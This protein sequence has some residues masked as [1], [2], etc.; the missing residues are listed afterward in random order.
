M[1]KKFCRSSK[2]QAALEFLTTYAWAFLVIL[3][4]IGALYY[5]GVFDFAKFLPQQC[6]FTSQFTCVDFSFVGDEVRLNLINNVGETVNIVS[7]DITNDAV[8]PLTC[9]S[10]ALTYPFEWKRGTDQDF[11]FDN[12]VGGVFSV[13]ERTEAKVTMT[14][15]SPA[16]SGCPEHTI[17]GKITAIVNE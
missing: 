8:S 12:C 15:C 4:T 9:T 6:L 5:F 14:Y 13:G 1:Q 16:T 11:V 10:P 7:F 2:S 3:I 17:T